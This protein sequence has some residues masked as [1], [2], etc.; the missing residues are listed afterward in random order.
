MNDSVASAGL[1]RVSVGDYFSFS[2]IIC[3]KFN[4]NLV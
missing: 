1:V 3:S 4:L 2:M